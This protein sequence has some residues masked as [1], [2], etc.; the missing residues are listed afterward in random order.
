MLCNK[1]AMTR[2]GTPRYADLIAA[3]LKVHRWKCFRVAENP[4]GAPWN[5]GQAL[6]K[7]QILCKREQSTWAEVLADK[8]DVDEMRGAKGKQRSQKQRKCYLYIIF[9]FC[10]KCSLGICGLGFFTD[11]QASLELS[12]I[13]TA[14]SVPRRTDWEVTHVCFHEQYITTTTTTKCKTSAKG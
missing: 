12:F 6:Q 13:S 10:Y 7:V 11:L 5:G 14:I 3:E 8:P 1:G 2:R 9:S 4:W